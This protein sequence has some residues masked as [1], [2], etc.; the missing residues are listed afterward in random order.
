MNNWIETDTAKIADNRNSC[1]SKKTLHFMMSPYDVPNAIRATS[2]EGS[3]LFII[4]FRYIAINEKRVKKTMDDVEFE[5]GENTQRIYKIFLDKNVVSQTE[6][7]F[8][9]SAQPDSEISLDEA[10]SAI[11]KFIKYNEQYDQN[12]M[13]YDG[14]K[15]ALHEYKSKLA[16]AE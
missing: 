1:A 15:L 12:T 8:D 2:E 4:E 9:I 10:E 16:H 6:L 3:S 11:E 7:V 14:A 13:K 5:V